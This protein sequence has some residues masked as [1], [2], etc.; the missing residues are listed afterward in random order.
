MAD[1]PTDSQ[2]GCLWRIPTE[3]V[4]LSELSGTVMCI[5]L[6]KRPLQRQR[7]GGGEIIRDSL[8][9]YFVQIISHQSLSSLLD[10]DGQ[11]ERAPASLIDFITAQTVPTPSPDHHLIL[12]PL[13]HGKSLAASVF[14]TVSR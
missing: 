11:V 8:T 1:R 14:S 13:L 2:R 5:R 3:E 6:C 10:S 9:V 4:S 12:F 7:V